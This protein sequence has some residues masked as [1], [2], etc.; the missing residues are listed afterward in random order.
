MPNQIEA[1]FHEAAH[2]VVAHTSAYFT[3]VG[4]VSI[5]NAGTGFT[6]IGL[7]R[8]KL[9]AASK[10]I[11]ASVETDPLVASELAVILLAGL[12]GEVIAEELNPSLRAD[13]D[14][15]EPDVTLAVEKL[16]AASVTVNLEEFQREARRRLEANWPKVDALAHQLVSRGSLLA[17]DLADHLD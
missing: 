6:D 5:Q 15:S 7:S 13:V 2:A 3:L 11:D 9:T 4:S 16:E 8:R 17:I 14:R 10:P 1:A 12:E